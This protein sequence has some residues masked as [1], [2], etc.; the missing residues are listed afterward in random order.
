MN[1]RSPELPD[2]ETQ[3]AQARRDRA[4][5]Q[6]DW[7]E[8]NPVLVMTVTGLLNFALWLALL[9]LTIRRWPSH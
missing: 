4:R 9:W 8:R 2:L 1:S 3:M 6:G 7:M 5:E